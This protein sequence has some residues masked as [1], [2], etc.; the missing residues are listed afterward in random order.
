M[1]IRALRSQDLVLLSQL[2]VSV[3]SSSPWNEYWEY[4][5][6][7]E[8]LNWVYQ[9]QGFIGFVVMD[10]DYIIGA[11]L[12]HFVPFKG[13]KGFEIVEFFVDAD[14][15]GKGAGTKLL[16]KLESKLKQKNYDFII[17]LTG[18]DTTAESFYLKRNYQPDNKLILL[19]QEI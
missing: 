11:I 1:E 8:R 14:Y 16:L 10:S 7:Y 4:D 6:A 3:F 5:W 19:Q 18:R 12:G 15:Q 13:K 2:Y 17:L 9:A